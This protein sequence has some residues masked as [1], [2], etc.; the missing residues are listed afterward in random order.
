MNNQK[1][2]GF[3]LVQALHTPVLMSELG[4]RRFLEIFILKYMGAA[5]YE[6]GAFDRHLRSMSEAISAS[7]IEAFRVVINGIPLYGIF[8]TRRCDLETVRAGIQS[9][10]DGV[11]VLKRHAD[12]PPR[13]KPP[14]VAWAEINLGVFWSLADYRDD[15]A[16]MIL[17]EIQHQDQA[18]TKEKA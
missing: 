14:A 15:V 1:L 17:R 11:A 7:Q 16:G 3:H 2:K 18:A 6:G 4:K 12:F 10:Y 8:D 9:V 5:Q 13:T